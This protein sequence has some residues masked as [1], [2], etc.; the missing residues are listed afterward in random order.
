MAEY[1]KGMLAVKSDS[2]VPQSWLLDAPDLQE[3]KPP[4]QE[5]AI[6]R[7]KAAGKNRFM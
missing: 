4:L 6:L 7:E 2:S 1:F 5:R 3:R